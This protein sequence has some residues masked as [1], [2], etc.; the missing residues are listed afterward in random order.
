MCGLI[1]TIGFKDNTKLDLKTISHRGPDSSGKWNSSENEFPATLGH[2]RLAI[3]DITEA[4]NQPLLADEDR[5]VLV[6]NGEIYN[7]IELR[8]E[9]ES[10]GHVFQTNTDT[11]VFLRGLIIE[12]PLFQLRCN[13]MWSFC[14]WDRKEKTALF[15]RDRFG[16]KPL[17]YSLIGTDKLVFASEMKGI[18][19]FLNKIEP[20]D[21]INI[22][23]QK[24]FDYE[25][26]EDCIIAG[27][28]RL[29]QGHYAF[30]KNG[31]FRSYRW[32]N[33]LDHLEDVSCSYDEQVEK[34]R[35][36]FLDS[37]RIRMRSDVR[38][39]TALS[40]GIDSSATFSAMNYLANLRV[41]KSR[42]SEDWQHGFCAHYPGSSLDE[43]KWA[44]IVTDAANVPLKK[45]EVDP[46]NSGWSINDAL[47]QVEDPYLTLPLPMLATYQAISKAGIKVTLDGHGADELFTGYGHLKHAFKSSN[48]IE[49][50]EL[51]SIINS[52]D[53]GEYNSY[54]GNIK[55]NYLRQKIIEFLKSH[56]RKPRDFLKNIFSKNDWE[57]IR[58]KLKFDDQS[59]Y[60]FKKLDPLSKSL[61][62][63]FHITVLPTLLRNYDR[64]SMSSGVEIRM[65]FMDHRL[66][67]YTFSL[68]WTSKVGGTHTKR[69]MR[70]ALKGI[71]PEK[72][73]VRRDK[74]GWNAPLHE[75][76]KGSLK[77][78]ID[79]LCKNDILTREAKDSW[80]KFQKKASPN[81]S[82]GQKIW[83]VLM[84][85]LWKRAII[86]QTTHK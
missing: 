10:L 71:L 79:E 50:A 22:Y 36:I 77:N 35:D 5:F 15:G 43:T 27:I 34:W 39:G 59:N 20:S 49:T 33:T 7:F 42:E 18:Y 44:R 25:S 69:I 55:I 67:T 24:L 4:G 58:Y 70:D 72:I 41:N 53:N 40:G 32:W 86:S 14:L 21:K 9:F 19:P 61:Y 75:W 30:F 38:I 85:E 37:V 2:T 16:K 8:S 11:E 12:G 45:V 13:G 3:L 66:V 47:F 23:L 60:Q 46:L 62:E 84:P 54:T 17:F 28:K 81:W 78:E 68:P 73:R 29:P 56:L 63:V 80:E 31:K 76:L 83:A 65:P 6:F 1:G 52:L 48:P 57:F 51:I 82:D 26:S 64:Y 74:I